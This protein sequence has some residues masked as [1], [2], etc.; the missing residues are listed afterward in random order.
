MSLGWSDP[1][2]QAQDLGQL[3]GDREQR[4]R[5]QTRMD[6]KPQQLAGEHAR[7]RAWRGGT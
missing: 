1:S 4:R 5:D 2:A 7:G 3:A 6:G